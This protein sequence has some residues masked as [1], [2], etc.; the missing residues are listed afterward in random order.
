MVRSRK[1]RYCQT[2]GCSPASGRYMHIR[3]IP[4]I[5]INCTIKHT[6]SFCVPPALLRS[7][8]QNREVEGMVSFSSSNSTAPYVLLSHVLVGCEEMPLSMVKFW[9]PGDNN[10]QLYFLS[11]SF[12][13]FPH[14][15]LFLLKRTVYTMIPERKQTNLDSRG[16]H[17]ILNL[18]VMLCQREK[19]EFVCLSCR[20]HAT[21]RYYQLIA[22][23][24][25]SPPFSHPSHLLILSAYPFL[26]H[27]VLF[28][29][30]KSK[31]R[32]KKRYSTYPKVIW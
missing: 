19:K 1:K 28:L 15:P 22:F 21:P 13:P 29:L 9:S 23:T 5:S 25:L 3:V 2:Y 24:P 30:L 14:F 18:R 6:K 12:T 27:L 32:K 4:K 16:K 7:H 10:N 20:Y 31:E 8:A 11:L 26:P 17:Q